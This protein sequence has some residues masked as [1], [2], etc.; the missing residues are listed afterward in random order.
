MLTPLVLF[1]FN[2]A[3]KYTFACVMETASLPFFFSLTHSLLLSFLH[4]AL[5]VEVG[6][7]RRL[8]IFVVLETKHTS[9]RVAQCHPI[10]AQY[11]LGNNK[12]NSHNNNSSRPLISI[13]I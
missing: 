1:R 7:L 6:H 8:L 3:Q 5:A 2:I 10:I 4:F 11:Y 9:V 13:P 12:N